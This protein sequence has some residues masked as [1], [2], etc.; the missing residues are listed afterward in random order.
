LEKTA[1]DAGASLRRTGT[2]ENT[3]G[4]VVHTE[5]RIRSY[6][7][8]PGDTFQW[9][10]DSLGNWQ[11][12]FGRRICPE[13]FEQLET[14]R[15][16]KVQKIRRWLSVRGI[17]VYRSDVRKILRQRGDIISGRELVD[18]LA[19][20]F[21]EKDSG[22][23]IQNQWAVMPEAEVRALDREIGSG[24]VQAAGS[25]GSGEDPV[26]W[27]PE[28]DAGSGD[29]LQHHVLVRQREIPG[30]ES[31]FYNDCLRQ[32][33]GLLKTIRHAF[34]LMKPEGIEILRRWPDGDAFDYRSL[35]DYAV[36]RK[37]GQSPSD[38]IYIKRVKQ[39]RNVA[40]LLLMDLSRS[41]SNRVAGTTATVLEVEKQAVV[42]FC[43]ALCV[44]GDQFAIAGY[45]GTGRLG[46]DYFSIKNFDEAVD[47]NVTGRI[48]ALAPQRNTR[49]GSAI[50]H[51][52]ELLHRVEAKV[53]LLILLGDG[54]PNDIDYKRRYAIED[55]RKALAEARSKNIHAHAIT[56][57]ISAHSGLDDLY[58][59]V[60]HNVISDV[61]DLPEKLLRIYRSLTR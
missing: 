5:A 6:F 44:V 22:N 51:A 16:K 10:V 47:G 11:T 4:W 55:T 18:R 36:E 40:V 32:H 2:V 31:G 50:R 21:V 46:A 15:E 26:F 61:R 13:L 42:L 17:R 58:G 29:Y 41:T 38:R 35:L 9:V 53:R 48:G 23:R 60:H 12:P 30:T 59:D 19:D 25:D 7:Q 34:E 1:L 24:V 57:N 39:R 56:V 54:F 45:S 8:A 52:S 20:V 3:A 49:M 28:W 33:S 37:S 14:G 27:Y 43:E